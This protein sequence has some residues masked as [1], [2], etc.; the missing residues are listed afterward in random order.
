MLNSSSPVQPSLSTCRLDM[1]GDAWVAKARC[2]LLHA[3]S[4]VRSYMRC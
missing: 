4:V 1:L 3:L 2:A